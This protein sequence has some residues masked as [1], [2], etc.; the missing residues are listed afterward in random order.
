MAPG[1]VVPLP[2]PL[3]GQIPGQ[4]LTTM[5]H[6]IGMIVM[7]GRAP[8]GMEPWEIRMTP[9][10]NFM[11][12]AGP[13]GSVVISGDTSIASTLSPNLIIKVPSVS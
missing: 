12:E 5:G 2:G 3:P 6:L 10:I 1:D 13:T 4:A 8:A 9:K 7:A 11:M